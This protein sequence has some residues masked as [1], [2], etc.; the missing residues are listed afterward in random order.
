MCHGFDGRA[1]DWGENGEPAFVGTEA[2][3]APNE[4]IGKIMNGPPGVAMINLRAFSPQAA[5]DVHS[6][7]ATMPK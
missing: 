6:D 7:V 2:A 3:A 5:H 1:Y 4:V